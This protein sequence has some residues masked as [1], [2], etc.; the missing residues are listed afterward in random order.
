MILL[1]GLWRY[2]EKTEKTYM[3]KAAF[4][5]KVHCMHN[6]YEKLQLS[7]KS[8]KVTCMHTRIIAGLQLQLQLQVTAIVSRSTFVSLPSTALPG[9]VFVRLY[10]ISGRTSELERPGRGR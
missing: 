1:A 6:S 7:N 2:E 10:H 3:H 8:L 9:N 4:I 5:G